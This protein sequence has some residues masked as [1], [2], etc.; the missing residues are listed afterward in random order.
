MSLD[1]H[2]KPLQKSTYCEYA[3]GCSAAAPTVEK[4][5][6]R[7]ISLI[8]MVYPFASRQWAS[9]QTREGF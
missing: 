7:I 1:Q 6:Q 9:A 3:G 8:A 2:S 4:F 5:Q